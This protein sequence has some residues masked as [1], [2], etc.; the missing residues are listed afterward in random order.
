M[1]NPETTSGRDDVQRPEAIQLRQIL[2]SRYGKILFGLLLACLATVVGIPFLPGRYSAVAILADKNKDL[3]EASVGD[4]KA[5][6]KYPARVNPNCFPMTLSE[7]LTSDRVIAQLAQDLDLP[8]RFKLAPGP[9]L[10]ERVRRMIRFETIV[11]TELVRLVVTDVEEQRALDIAN[12]LYK[13]YRMLRESTL[14]QQH[15]QALEVL[16]SQIKEQEEKLQAARMKMEE[17]LENADLVDVSRTAAQHKELE[18][19]IIIGNARGIMKNQSKFYELVLD[20]ETLRAQIKGLEG[21]EGDMLVRRAVIL[22]IED[23]IIQNQGPMFQELSLAEEQAELMGIGPN[24]PERKKTREE[25]AALRE[26][27]VRAAEDLRRKLGTKL[28]MSEKQLVDAVVTSTANHSAPQRTKINSA[29]FQ[30]SIENYDDQKEILELLK[31]E[32]QEYLIQF[33]SSPL[34]LVLCKE[35]ILEPIPP[36]QNKL[37]PPILGAVT[38]LLLGGSLVFLAARNLAAKAMP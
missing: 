32:R 37:L 11:G 3:T 24:H 12:G 9:G 8:A 2:R 22:G 13:A 6:G 7:V 33:A 29:V 5:Y 38:A 18:D 30:I 26:K 21:C 15:Q 36:Y 34:P 20:L 19:E 17:A 25:M 31:D 14:H 16:D 28:A 23:E 27:L 35:A 10:I 4:G 1:T